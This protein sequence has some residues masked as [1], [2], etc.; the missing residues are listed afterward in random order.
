MGISLLR[1]TSSLKFETVGMVQ[2]TDSE[3]FQVT[4]VMLR[5]Q[6]LFVDYD[7]RHLS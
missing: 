5:L 4:W 2:V 3:R 6:I 7:T 1:M